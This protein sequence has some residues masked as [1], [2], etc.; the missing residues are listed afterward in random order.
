MSEGARAAPCRYRHALVVGAGPGLGAALARRF[1]GEGLRVSLAARNP[2]RLDDVCRE[3]GARAYV[4]DASSQSQVSRLFA[5]FGGDEPD[6]VVYNAGH[7]ARGGIAEIDPDAARESLEINALGA[8]LVAREAARGMLSRSHG[9]LL[10]TGATASIKAY[11]GSAP[12]AMGKFALRALAQSLARELS[13]RGIHVAHF[14]I[15][16]G[17]LSQRREVDADR[18]DGWLDPA[19]IAEAYWSVA[20]QHRS[21][22]TWELELRPWLEK[23]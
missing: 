21:A 3:T 10:F 2:S 22:W 9:A 20:C 7:R 12:F 17:I 15:D 14:V 1:A 23:F 11:A 18:P 13:P 16:G 8:L 5:G 19:A 6:L 4:C